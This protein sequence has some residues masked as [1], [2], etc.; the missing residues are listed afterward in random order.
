MTAQQPQP[1]D[2]PEAAT[3]AEPLP[4]TIYVFRECE[5]GDP[6]INWL[7]AEQEPYSCV[8]S[9]EEK[10]VGEYR[11]HRMVRVRSIVSVIPEKTT[12]PTEP[13]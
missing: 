5:P 12:D 6:Q 4:E 2:E 1:D 9:D 11:L 13:R 3:A 8:R 10:V 7:I